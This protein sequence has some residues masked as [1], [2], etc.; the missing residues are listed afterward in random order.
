VVVVLSGRLVHELDPVLVEQLHPFGQVGVEGRSD[1]Q[2][3]CVLGVLGARLDGV[4]G[5][6][7]VA[8]SAVDVPFDLGRV[9]QFV[10]HTGA[11]CFPVVDVLERIPKPLEGYRRHVH[12]VTDVHVPVQR[13]A[14]VVGDLVTVG[15]VVPA[16]VV[17]IDPV[18]HGAADHTYVDGRIG[19]VRVA[20]ADVQ[21]EHRLERPVVDLLGRSG[22][23]RDQLGSLELSLAF[24]TDHEHRVAIHDQ[25]SDGDDVV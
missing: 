18:L 20:A 1:S 6:S 5:C 8:R 3:R 7:L 15:F 22:R 24:C 9:D 16:E 10:A 4:K 17:E 2:G 23:N 25:L 19:H 13:G 14:V 12:P 11:D 21:P